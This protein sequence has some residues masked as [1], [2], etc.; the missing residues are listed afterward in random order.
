MIKNFRRII[1]M[2]LAVTIVLAGLPMLN[3]EA[4]EVGDSID[5]FLAE[6]DTDDACFGPF[7]YTFSQLFAIVEVTHESMIDMMFTVENETTNP[8]AQERHWNIQSIV[9]NEE[10]S[11]YAIQ[12]DINTSDITVKIYDAHEAWDGHPGLCK[13]CGKSMNTGSGSNQPCPTP[14]ESK[15]EAPA[16]PPTPAEELRAAE[17]EA[18]PLAIVEKDKTQVTKEEVGIVPDK[19]YNLSAYVTTKGFVSALNKITKANAEAKS[20][21]IFTGK[22]F[23]FNKGIVEAINKGG[24]DVVYFFN[25][26]EHLYSVTVP[27]NVDPTSILEKGGHAGPL[28]VGKVLGTT[29]LVK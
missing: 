11:A 5:Q 8:G 9:W 29:R 2:L 26:K 7:N 3:V 6:V 23:T 19:A 25:Y 24:K 16:E 21:S 10:F 4:A 13:N 28:Y 27:A 12:S 15:K 20:V 22:P 14:S 18:L 1:T 17:E